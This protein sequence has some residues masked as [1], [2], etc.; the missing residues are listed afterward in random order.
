MARVAMYIDGVKSTV[1]KYE[2]KKDGERAVDELKFCVVPTQNV[3]TNESVTIVQDN[4]PLCNLSTVWTFQEH[5]LNQSGNTIQPNGATDTPRSD[6][7]LEFECNVNNC[8]FRNVTATAFGC[9]S[10]VTGKPGEGTMAI[11]L[12]GSTNYLTLNKECEF[13]YDITTSQS[14]NFWIKTSS[15]AAGAIIAKKATGIGSVGV[16]VSMNACGKIVFDMLNTATTNELKVTSDFTVNDGNWNMI[17]VTFGGV[18]LASS[19][20]MYKNAVQ[21]TFSTCANTLTSSILNNSLV[22]VGA[23]ADGSS[24]LTAQL[25]DTR[26]IGSKQISS[27]EITALYTHEIF[28]YID[29]KFGSAARFNGVDTRF[30]VEDNTKL[31][32][33]GLFD[34]YIWSKW[35]STATQY[36]MTKRTLSGNGFGIS[37]NRFSTGDISAEVDGKFATASGTYND[38]VWHLIRVYRDS[39]NTV[40]IAVDDTIQD[41][42]SQGSNMTLPVQLKVG[43]NHND[44]SYFAGDI[45]IIRIYKDVNLTAAE[46]TKMYA[47][48]NATQITKFGGY[49]TK[50]DK[51]IDRKAVVAQS[52]GKILGETEIRGEVY[53]L[54]SPE[55]IV[56]DLIKSN[57]NLITHIHGTPSGTK[58][59]TYT[60]DGKLIDIVKNLTQLVGKSFYTDGV[61]QLHVHDEQF[62]CSSSVVF[63]HGTNSTSFITKLDDTEIVNDLVV[64]GENKRYSTNCKFSGDGSTTEFIVNN[65]PVVSKVTIS[66][67]EQT[68]ECDY[69]VCSVLQKLTFTCAPACGACNICITYNYELP[70][71]IRGVKQSSINTYGRHAKRIIAPWITN[72]QDGIKYINGY[73]NRFKNVRTNLTIMVPIHSNSVSEGH[74]VT[75]S[76][77]PKSINGTF[78]IKSIKYRYPEFV[79][80]ID[81]GEF[82]FDDLEYEKQVAQKI[83]DLEGAVT[84][85]KSIRDF[86]SFEELLGLTDN[87]FVQEASLCGT[88]YTETLTLTDGL[89]VTVVQPAVYSVSTYGGGDIYGSVQV[90]GGFTVSGFTSSGF[91][92]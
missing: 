89:C 36:I 83:H 17:S 75:V 77:T 48:R 16:D 11:C 20:K 80:E 40:R 71:Y 81:V 4:F 92:V 62:T 1:L 70:L 14:Y 13:D 43:S 18:P 60:A 69:V 7:I 26:I 15:S 50:I 45:N 72:R 42:V 73:I 91:T 49:I 23:Y 12:D 34:V 2:L 68:P 6:V 47:N 38:D 53:Q 64:L 55:F 88:L 66:G 86:E 76:N 87:F 57:T 29:G 33:S 61:G 79:T 27:S 85:I 82:T 63:T 74:I 54:R 30:I 39:T 44:I 25:D 3:T 51:E 65:A 9:P 31:N 67:T 37:V 19:V 5:I 35:Q 90:P 46:H 28:D 58:I 78:V 10:Y 32:F 56:E 84:T 59:T 21:G 52:F 24:K 41:S 22:S 8:G